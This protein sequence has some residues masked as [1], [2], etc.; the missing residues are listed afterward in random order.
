MKKPNQNVV[1]NACVTAVAFPKTVTEL[2]AMVGP[3]EDGGYRWTHMEELLEPDTFGYQG[4]NSW[5]APKW[6]SE[7]DILFFYHTKGAYSRIVRLLRQSKRLD[8]P[9]WIGVEDRDALV[10]ILETQKVVAEAY[11]GGIFA[12]S[13]VTGASFAQTR[14]DRP[15]GH[16]RGLIF[17]PIDPPIRFDQPIFDTQ[18]GDY[19][20][21]STGG[22][23]TPLYSD[24]FEGLVRDVSRSNEVPKWLERAK[25][26]DRT[27]RDVTAK[28][29]AT[30]ARDTSLRFVVESQLR[31]FLIDHLLGELK[32]PRI[33]ILRECRCDDGGIA[34]YFVRIGGVWTAVEAKLRVAVEKDL[35]G[36]VRRYLNTSRIVPTLGVNSGESRPVSP[37]ALAIVVDSDGLYLLNRKGFVA[38]DALRP[39]LHRRD[40]QD[41]CA[42][43]V[44]SLLKAH[45]PE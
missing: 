34:D 41:D 32:D 11:G 10:E 7:G 38:C 2:L 1:A 29:W 35:P 12:A 3:Y 22:T 15:D 13:K 33:P 36:Q 25:L 18:F 14:A 39:L 40:F 6:M 42:K 9:D 26:G 28:N 44:L 24:A 43:R 17:A 30:F 31:A 4:G 27:F 20:A 21:L 5:T 45:V 16:F 37:A 23:T 19:L 8:H